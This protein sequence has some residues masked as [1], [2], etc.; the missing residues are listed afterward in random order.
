MVDWFSSNEQKKEIFN[1][2][3]TA[4]IIAVKGPSNVS[5]TMHISKFVHTSF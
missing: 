1:N 4:A 2:L 5:P 3:L